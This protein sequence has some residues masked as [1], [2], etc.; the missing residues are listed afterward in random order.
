MKTHPL[1]IGFLLATA[2]AAPTD[3][4]YPVG[5]G[6]NP[7]LPAPEHSLLPTV[8]VARTEPWKEQEGPLPTPGFTVTAY[9]R[10]L[11]HPRWLYVLPN[12]DVLVAETNAPPKPDDSQGIRGFITRIEMKGAGAAGASPDRITLLRGVD[13]KGAAQ[14]RNVFLSGL[15]SPF[16][17]ALVGNELYVADSDAV[18]RYPY[19]AGETSIN[20][21]P[22]KVMDLPA[23]RINHHWTKNIIASPDGQYLYVTVGSNSNVGENGIDKEEGRAAIWQLERSS[24]KARIYATGLRNANGMG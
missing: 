23:G 4:Q 18:V 19:Q 10:G 16:G 17:M 11:D 14:S 8:N 15:H 6:P 13:A 12:G 24:G 5:Y 1:A 9:A 3:T 22:T 21:A 2:L 7:V 20:A